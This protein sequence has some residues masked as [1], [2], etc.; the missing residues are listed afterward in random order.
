MLLLLNR[1]KKT[2][3]TFAL[4]QAVLFLFQIKVELSF[5]R[6]KHNET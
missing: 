6:D 3:G 5:K 2:V 1:S 4:I